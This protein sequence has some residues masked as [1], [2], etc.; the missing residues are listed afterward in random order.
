MQEAYCLLNTKYSLW[1]SVS[2]GTSSCSGQAVPHPVL[3]LGYPILS[4]PGGTQSCPHMYD[5]GSPNRDWGT[6]WKDRDQWKYYG[7]VPP[8]SGK[9]MGPVELLW[10]ED[11]VPLF[12][13]GQTWPVKTVSTHPSDVDNK[14]GDFPLIW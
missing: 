7:M 12:P 4:W 10:D 13:C 5:C 14:N 11:G 1:C 2:R 3:A 8:P 6:P 9:D